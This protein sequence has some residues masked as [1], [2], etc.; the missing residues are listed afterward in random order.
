MALCV[1]KAVLCFYL[2]ILLLSLGTSS[3]LQCRCWECLSRWRDHDCPC[4]MFTPRNTH[5]NFFSIQS[6]QYTQ[7]VPG[8]EAQRAS[9]PE[10]GL[11]QT[12]I[13]P[14]SSSSSSSTSRHR[15]LCL[16]FVRSCWCCAGSYSQPARRRESDGPPSLSSP[17]HRGSIQSPCAA[18]WPDAAPQSPASP[19]IRLQSA[20]LGTITYTGA[21]HP[22]LPSLSLSLIMRDHKH[23]PN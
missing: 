3:S 8:W 12:A 10:A 11:T 2:Y 9:S 14:G 5:M 17:A 15:H 4:W 23:K 13:I 16:C 18:L 20:K 6:K 21:S 22:P 1:L 19:W 7:K